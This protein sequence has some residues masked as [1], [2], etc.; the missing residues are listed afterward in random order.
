MKYFFYFIKKLFLYKKYFFYF[1]ISHNLNKLIQK[2][3]LYYKQFLLE[4]EVFFIDN[5]F[6]IYNEKSLFSFLNLPVK[7][8]IKN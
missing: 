7:E 8:N 5:Y 1:F 3:I 2:M 4:K 6:S